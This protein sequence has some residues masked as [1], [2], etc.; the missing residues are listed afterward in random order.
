MMRTDMFW[1]EKREE[2]ICHPQKALVKWVP[3]FYNTFA[4]INSST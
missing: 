2:K 4:T 3:Y 1:K